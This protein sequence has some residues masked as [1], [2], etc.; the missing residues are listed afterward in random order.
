MPGTPKSDAA[1]RAAADAQEHLAQWRHEHPRATLREIEAAVDRQMARLRTT[2]I[3]QVAHQEQDLARPA[4]PSCGVAM[5]RVGTRE[6]TV[7]TAQ[8]E[9]LPLRGPGYRCP[10]CGA[11]LF[12][13]R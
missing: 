3:V 2:L 8:D 13:P 7:L 9:T 4:C 6:R 11:G 5:Q 10:A 12:P 1:T